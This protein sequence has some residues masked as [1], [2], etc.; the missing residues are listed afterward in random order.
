[1]AVPDGVVAWIRGGKVEPIELDELPDDVRRG[2]LFGRH[3]DRG[4]TF[5]EDYGRLWVAS[6]GSPRTEYE[7]VRT[8]VGI[9]DVSPLAKWHITGPDAMAALDRLTTRPTSADDP[10][11]V[12]Y[13]LL[14][15]ERGLLVDEGTRYVFG[16]E[17]AWFIGNEDRTPMT[18][19]IVGSMHDL[20]VHVADRTDDL[21]SI[22]VQGPRSCA[23]LAPLVDA[24]LPSLAYYRSFPSCTVAGVPAFVSRTGFSGELGYEVFLDGDEEGAARVWDRIVEA[25][26]TPIG[27]DA[28]EILRV[29][30]GFVVADEDYVTGETDPVEV[31]LERFVDLAGRFIGREAVGARIADADRR[32]LTLTFDEDVDGSGGPAAV[33]RDGIDVGEVRSVA[34]SPRFGSIGLAVIDRSV[35]VGERVRALGTVATVAERPIDAG[36]RARRSL[37]VPRVGPPSGV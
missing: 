32:L 30:A 24:D 2:P 10:G 29:E 36:D 23:V 6:F 1:M 34:R 25:G 37:P 19:H 4:A 15:N 31:S 33:R 16:P 3:R 26:A 28:V 9:W 17:E 5:Y 8:D 7:A 13:L 35:A 27:L 12:R 20:A 11:Q 22:A 21:A 18:E 14:L